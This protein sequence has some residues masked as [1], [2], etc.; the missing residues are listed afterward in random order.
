MTLII[1]IQ[2]AD[3]GDLVFDGDLS[4][5]TGAASV[6]QRV[7]N[8]LLMH[9]GQWFLDTREGAPWL[10]VLST[11]GGRGAVDALIRAEAARVPGVARIESLRSVVDGEKYTATFH[12]IAT[13]GSASPV[14]VRFG[15]DNA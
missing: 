5:V 12:V 9:R 2:Q 10:A 15:V 7:K 8:A 13:D 3:D 11:D 6:A 4:T 14:E 1:D